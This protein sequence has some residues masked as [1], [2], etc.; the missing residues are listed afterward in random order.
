[1]LPCQ[2]AARSVVTRRP[3]AGAERHDSISTPREGSHLLQW[4]ATTHCQSRLVP[5]FRRSTASLCPGHHP[6]SDP[7]QVGLT[8]SSAA[9]TIAQASAVARYR[10][11]GSSIRAVPMVQEPVEMDGKPHG[12]F[13][14]VD[15]RASG[16]CGRFYCT[17]G[18][19]VSR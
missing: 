16:R 10:L 12:D 3:L 11:A 2:A 14:P 7:R 1:M 6:Y 17:A 4:G 13:G 19:H 5:L 8:L 9:S 18:V 15:S